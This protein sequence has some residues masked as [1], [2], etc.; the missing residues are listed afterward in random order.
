VLRLLCA[1]WEAQPGPAG[2]LAADLLRNQAGFWDS[3]KPFVPTAQGSSRSCLPSQD[4]DQLEAAAYRM[5]AQ[6]SCLNLLLLEL[7]SVRS[8]ALATTPATTANAGGSASSTPGA[9]A[10]AAGA[11]VGAAP[12]SSTSSNSLAP[13][14]ALLGREQLLQLLLGLAATGPS[15]LQQE[16]ALPLLQEFLDVLQ[17]AYL[18]LCSA[19]VPD[20]WWDQPQGQAGGYQPQQFL[21]S[22]ARELRAE[23][24]ACAS[25]V[26]G[27]TVLF[28]PNGGLNRSAVQLACQMLVE[29][30]APEPGEGLGG[31]GGE[32]MEEDGEG[33]GARLAGAALVTGLRRQPL[34]QVLMA[35]ASVTTW[36]WMYTEAEY[37][38]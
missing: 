6:A 19:A 15:P 32:D 23:V 26:G 27:G 12:N 31:E 10:G 5:Q 3:L 33:Q 36:T 25:T 34:G 4:P 11:I 8:A 18:Q 29:G 22:C 38:R 21:L 37:G 14:L 17:A 1:A 16:L 28:G 24:G 7:L 30:Q 35:Y 9:A 2:P 20:S 13:L